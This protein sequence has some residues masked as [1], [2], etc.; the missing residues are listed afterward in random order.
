VTSLYVGIVL[1]TYLTLM[2][3]R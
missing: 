1:L 3:H 2:L